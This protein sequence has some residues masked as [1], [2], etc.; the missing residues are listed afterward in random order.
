MALSRKSGFVLMA[1]LVLAAYLAGAVPN[2]LQ[3]LDLRSHA[4][5]S[6]GR[7]MLLTAQSEL[8]MAVAEAQNANFGNAREH[9][10]AFFDL[11]GEWSATVGSSAP[12]SNLASLLNRRDE[13]AAD[14]QGLK[15]EAAE[16]L[17]GMYRQ[18]YEAAK[19]MK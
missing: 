15:A 9:A 11:L 7:M 12:R 6:S 1:V 13:I 18:V 17:R 3:V 4:R 10:T 8:G 2:Y 19:A 14:L 16:K 5:T